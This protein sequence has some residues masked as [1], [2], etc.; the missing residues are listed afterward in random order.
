MIRGQNQVEIPRK[1]Q[2]DDGLTKNALQ[3]FPHLIA[4]E[5]TREKLEMQLTKAH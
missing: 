4:L 1:P 5:A 3:K 2:V